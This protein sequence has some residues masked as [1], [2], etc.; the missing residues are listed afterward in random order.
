MEA[1]RSGDAKTQ[2]CMNSSRCMTPLFLNFSLSPLPP[3]LVPDG[4]VL[5]CFQKGYHMASR[6]PGSTSS[7]SG[8]GDDAE[9]AAA[10][11][12]DSGTDSGSE[13]GA[14]PPGMLVR[15]ALVKVSMQ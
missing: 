1:A 15:P 5:S 2:A 7:S 13:E 10:M 6:K 3:L 11:E 8:E 9:G 14:A 12:V 4:T